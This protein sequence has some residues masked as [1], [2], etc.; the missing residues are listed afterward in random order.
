MVKALRGT[1]ILRAAVTAAA[2]AWACGA[3]AQ[4]YPARPITFL[5]NI[6]GGPQEA[7]KRAV[8]AKVKEN[9]GATFL[10]EGRGG[11]GGA[12]GLQAVKNAPSDGYTFGLTYQS[13]MTLNPL[14]TPELGIDPL[15]D[16]VPVTKLWFSGNVWS[17][18]VDYPAKDLRDLVAL[19]K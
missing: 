11:G 10:Y 8:F 4:T 3:A 2:L 16:Y 14:M 17:A 7:L 9:S 15:K 19:A 6:P 5:D 13:A 1:R 12:P 18:R